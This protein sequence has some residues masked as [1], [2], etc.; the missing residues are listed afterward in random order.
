MKVMR[1]PGVWL[2]LALLALTGCG[3]GGV[4]TGG[5]CTGS[6]AVTA[7]QQLAVADV[8]QVVATAKASGLEPRDVA[9]WITNIANRKDA[10]SCT[11]FASTPP[12]G[13]CPSS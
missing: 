13:C 6:C 5:G 4:T 2:P 7:P 1:R 9:E 10:K 3:G 12:R 8:Q 11:M